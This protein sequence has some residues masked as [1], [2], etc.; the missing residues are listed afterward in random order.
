MVPCVT[1]NALTTQKK[2]NSARYAFDFRRTVDR[3]GLIDLGFIGP[4]FTWV[5]SSKQPSAGKS[6]K[7]ARLDRGLASTDWRILFPDAVLNHLSAST[8]DHRPILLDTNGGYKGK[9]HPFRYENMW[10]RD[11]RCYW[12]V[13]EAWAKRLHSNPMVNFHRKAKNTRRKLSQWNKDQFRKLSFQVKEANSYLQHTEQS[14]PDDLNAIEAARQQLKEALLWEEIHWKQKSR[15]QWL[16]EGDRCS[17]FF[18]TSTIVR[19]R[20]SFIQCIKDSE[21]GQWIRD[22]KEIADCFLKNF[23]DLF[24]QDQNC[25]TPQLS[26]LF[27]QVI[28]NEENLMLNAIPNTEEVTAAI[29]EM[30]NDKAPGPDG[31]PVS[32]Y[33]HHWGTIGSDLHEMIIATRLRGILT[34]IISPTQAAFVKGRCIAENTMIAQEVVHFMKKRRGK[35]GF[36][37]IKI[38]MEKAYEKLSWEFIIAV[39][40]Q[41]GLSQP[42]TNWI[43]ACIS[44]KEIKLLLNGSI[45]GRI[46]PGRGLRQGD[47]LSPMLFITAAETL[48]RLIFLKEKS[49]EI[50]G[51]KMGRNDTTVNHLMFADDIILFGGVCRGKV[52]AI[53]KYFGMK[54]MTA[55]A[56]YLGLPLFKATKRTEDYIQL[57]DKVLGRVKGWKSKLLSSAVGLLSISVSKKYISVDEREEVEDEE[58]EIIL[59]LLPIRTR[60]EDAHDSRFAFRAVPQLI[61]FTTTKFSSSSSFPHGAGL[62]KTFLC[63]VTTTIS[64]IPNHSLCHLSLPPMIPPSLR[65]AAPVIGLLS[66]TL[67]SAPSTVPL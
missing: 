16:Q 43:R 60:D 56:I 13:K 27:D 63:T 36:I 40:N 5:K 34:K 50:K 17:K 41:I 38:D 65:V 39:L 28:T 20:K 14:N 46:K 3:A 48:S 54:E 15:I 62:E 58:R 67:D 66:P 29:N 23:Q 11:P 12:V 42:L 59:P 52:R 55:N 10:A 18:M 2:S 8:S 24:R 19:R 9:R 33:S 57:I 21:G 1:R 53:T 32:F 49:G 35:R 26:N 47:P 22:Q 4:P 45:E 7:R 64:F 6:L 30:G 37:M 44:T 61:W 51:F 31:F 25:P